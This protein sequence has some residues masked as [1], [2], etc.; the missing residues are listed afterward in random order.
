MYT[1]THASDTACGLGDN[2]GFSL[3]T[4]W[5][6]GLKHNLS[7]LQ[8]APHLLSH[9]SRSQFLLLFKT[10]LLVLVC[11]ILHASVLIF[12]MLMLSLFDAKP[13]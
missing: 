4:V 11:F 13:P 1:H 2:S 5:V 9:L 10:L 3:A 12:P 6:L 8:K 7:G